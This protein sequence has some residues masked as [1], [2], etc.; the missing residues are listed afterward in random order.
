MITS[1]SRQRLAELSN[2]FYV[3]LQV[4]ETKARQLIE[5]S[6]GGSNI[7]FTPH[8]LSH[9][10]AVERNYDWLLAEPDLET[11]NPPELFF[12]L[13]ATFF[14]DALMVPRRATEGAAARNNH[15]DRAQ[16]FLISSRETL[17]LS[18]HEADSI[19]QVIRAH[20]VANLNDIPPEVVIGADVVD[21]R[22]LGACLSIADIT[23]ADTSRAPEIVFHHLDLD[24]ESQFH[25]RRHLQISGITRK[26]DG[27]L[28]SA[29]T[30]S[31]SGAQAVR[32][33]R[34][35]IERQLVIVRPYFDSILTK[36]RRVELIER[37]LESPL[38]QVLQFQTNTPAILRLLIEGVYDRD[39]VFIRELVQNSLDSCLIRRAKQHRRNLEYKP[40]VLISVFSE[41]DN[42]RALRVDDNGIG[43]D[44]SDIQDTVLWIGSSIGS[45]AEILNLLQHTIGKSPIATFGIGL[46]SCFKASS[47][48]AVRTRKENETPLQ[49]E[50][51][52]VSD[53]I[54]PERS[55]DTA[56]GTTMVVHLSPET[57]TT[58][59]ARTAIDFYF[60][61]IRQVD[62]RV[63]HLEWSEELTTGTRDKFFQIAVTESQGAPIQDYVP[64][65]TT[66]PALEIYGDDFS[67]GVWITERN[68]AKLV[69]SSGN[70]EILNEGI[71]V[72]SEPAEDWLPSHFAF[73][74][75]V[76]NFSS[77]ALTLPAGRDRV[78]RDEQ[79]HQRVHEIAEKSL[80]MVDHLVRWTRTKTEWYRDYAAL[81]LAYMYK[82]AGPEHRSKLLRRL[83][84]FEVRRYKSKETI[85]LADLARYRS[86][87]IYLQYS[88]G[89]WV[90]ELG[91]F[92]DKKLYHK[93]DDFVEL[94]SAV[95]AQKG[96][97]VITA[98]RADKEEALL[99]ATLLKAY[100]A[101]T[102]ATLTDLTEVNVV[103]GMQRSRP[104]PSS[105]RQELGI[106]LKFV[107][108]SGL[109]NKNAWKVG[110]EVWI[111]IA[112][113]SM[114]KVYDLLQD[115]GSDPA[116][117]RL[118]VILFEMMS[119]QFDTAARKLVS[120]IDQNTNA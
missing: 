70:V 68:L 79:Y 78:I 106:S 118:A 75:G 4:I 101:G 93:E 2:E 64:P 25:W 76:L 113:P 20:G 16:K 45:K 33:Y 111:N 39:D 42:C 104:V 44:L 89:R 77:R 60:R 92:N 52:G 119:Y 46:L 5:Y 22:K 82:E 28:M 66:L 83:G 53:S 26:G 73:C 63:M 59:Q 88:K 24:E 35:S 108:I 102:G 98:A 84:E 7:S 55:D 87:P 41:G 107:F 69:G 72:S 114:R 14:H 109:P 34:D 86:A 21:L 43:M 17:G 110:S 56:V 36:I 23:H 18:L 30:F 32:D 31:D 105:V 1:R 19:G 50:I 9:I 90:Q 48:I 6:Q 67:G 74:D 47:R 51:G 97:M 96:E 61:M 27:I 120:I 13:C 12:L 54:K 8:G 91:V 95:L 11:F 3:R 71:F 117:I 29:L 81:V 80:G 40:Q 103:E 57:I 112:N 115:A 37:Q 58:L 38:Q 85:S 65:G 49:F 94:Q 62:L 116:M 100:F 15:V 10:S 99:E